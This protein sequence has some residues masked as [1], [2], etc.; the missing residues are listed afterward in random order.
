AHGAAERLRSG[1]DGGTVA[2]I[3][4]AALVPDL[5]RA[6]APA[7]PADAAGS[8]GAI[9][10]LTPAQAKGLEFDVV[11]LVEPARVLAGPG[12]ASDLYVAMTRP[13]RS[14]RIVHHEP[15]PPG[16]LDGDD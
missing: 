3:A 8:T 7:L 13:T 4:P 14:L 15:L 1:A 2:V 6:T 16:V 11:V 9:S 5:A 10:V 12:G